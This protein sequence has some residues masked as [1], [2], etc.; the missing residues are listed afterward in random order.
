MFSE[1]V[2][3]KWRIT[4]SRIF[5]ATL[6]ILVFISTSKW[7]NIGVIS[8]ILFLLGAVLIGIAT[9][10]RLWCSLYISGYKSKTLITTGPYS[11]CR[12]PLY[13]FS[14]I[15]GLG[16]GLTTE[17]FTIP[18]LILIGFAIYYPYVIKREHRRLSLLHADR[19]QQYC[20]KIPC[21]I[22]SIA[23]FK[24]PEEYTVKP[25]IFRKNL[26]DA[27]CFIW[28]VGII[29]LVEGLHEAQIIPVLFSIY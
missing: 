7:E 26:F 16:A 13:F 15:G 18:L 24:E 9:V 27:L 14:L 8:T 11:M 2:F 25:K 19:Y 20:D 22:P 29:E 1:K 17:T 12:N 10:G 5:V 28:I 4:L 23:Q 3:R 21:F 6:A